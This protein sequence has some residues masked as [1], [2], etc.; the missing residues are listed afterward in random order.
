MNRDQKNKYDKL[1]FLAWFL[2]GL[3]I[4]R[5]LLLMFGGT[6]FLILGTAILLEL[7][8]IHQFMQMIQ[9]IAIKVPL[10]TQAV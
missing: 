5:W 10:L 6:V 3:E 8:P 7:H 2:P 1:D 9:H 4:K